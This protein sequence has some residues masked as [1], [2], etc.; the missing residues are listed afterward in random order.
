[1]PFCRADA[2]FLRTKIDNFIEQAAVEMLPKQGQHQPIM[3]MK[4]ILRFL[5]IVLPAVALSSCYVDGHAHGH[6][7]Y[8]GYRP[9]HTN[10]HY[11]DRGPAPR[12]SGPSINANTNLGLRL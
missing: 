11:Y 1:M 6:A 8:P 4:H 5:S 3:L 2:H 9:G 10:H 7:R 12:R